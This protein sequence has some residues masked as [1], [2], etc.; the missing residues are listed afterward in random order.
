M[1]KTYTPS[2]I[3]KKW[4][5]IWEQRG[6]FKPSGEG[7]AYCI[8]IPP[9]N[10]TGF[11]HMGHGF[12][13]TLMD[14]LIRYHRMDG[15][16][17][18]WQTGTDHAGIATQMVVERQLATQKL[19]RHDLGREAFVE[20]VWEWKAESG[21]HITRQMRRI[22]NSADW[23]REAF[24]MDD[25]LSAAVKKVFVQLYD[26]G[27]IYR[28]KR[29]VN[30]DPVL[31][32]AISDVEVINET[33][34]G[35][36]WYL[37]YPL[38][39]GS[40]HLIVATTRPETMLGD[41]AVAVNPNDERYQHLIGKEIALPLTSRKIP[42]IGDDYA[43]PKFGTGCVKITPAH[44]FNDYEVGLRHQLRLI[45]ILTPDAKINHEAPEKYRGLDRFVA[46]EKIIED[47]KA[48][49]LLEKIE[50]HTLNVPIGDRGGAVIEPYLTNQ[51]YVD[52][53]P[54]AK[55]AIDAV[56][57]GRIR[58]VPDTWNKTYFQWMDNIQDWCISRQL[59]WGHRIPA[60]YDASGN[61]YVADDEMTVRE[62]Y[63]L[64]KS[65][66]LTQDND[67]LDTWFSSALWPFSTLGWPEKT[68]ALKIFY[69]T[70]VL[71][72]G[73]D[74][75]F[76]WVARMIMFG[77][78]FAGDVPFHDIYITGLIR[79]E[80]GQKMSKTK[81]NVLDPIDLV[82][83]ISLED[84][85]AKRTYGLMQTHLI[86]T[87]IDNTRKQFPEGIAAHGMDA[88]RF[89]FCALASTGR[90]IRFDLGRLEGYKNFCNKIWNATRFVLM[91][92][93]GNS[94]PCVLAGE[95]EGG[96]KNLAD[97]WILSRLQNAIHEFRSHLNNYRFDLASQA[98]YDFIWNEYCDWYL[99][100]T[101]PILYNDTTS[102]TEKAGTRHTLIF[103][104]ETAL[105][106]LH[107]FMPFMT[108]E[109]WQTVKPLL[110]IS[111]DSIMLQPYPQVDNS[112]VNVSA[113]ESVELFKAIILGVRTIRGEMGIPPS[114]TVKLYFDKASS[115]QKQAI[116][117][118]QSFLL[119]LA[120]CESI[121][122]G[123]PS[124]ASAAAL[125]SNLELFIPLA[126]FIDKEAEIQRLNKEIEKFK[127]E[128]VIS[129][130][131]LDN[132]GYVAKAPA[133]V[134][135]KERDKLIEKETNL[136]KLKMQL[137]KIKNI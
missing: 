100:F 108:E 8:M 27:L 41:S 31:L 28:G 125:A 129:S 113:E 86:D 137:E 37:R 21:G 30:W 70:S 96:G 92:V 58:F 107:P 130:K 123:N 36:M 2:D 83:G 99:E 95:G 84:L 75:I 25:N 18:L 63:N 15:D 114:K 77:L 71:M 61:V 111:G 47:L 101:K 66:V 1:E 6:Y 42:I 43:D 93:E 48:L 132:Q 67:V 88:L 46:R 94:L 91:N 97:A 44:D 19:A 119:A 16:N 53:K 105:R 128:I 89:T 110:A 103:V 32:T 4:Y 80:H 112:L 76:F 45:N 56:K 136:E 40:G 17:T 78:K 14:V 85:L 54:L 11:L 59:W 124:A 98:I 55:P 65:I 115:T 62:K 102:D 87:I 12:Q 116:E 90:D 39:D 131:K 127:A 38:A 49:G 50:P 81:G 57:D 13:Q 126:G 51:W 24:T 118:N 69:P 7:K 74:I 122:E 117:H 120:K 34:E 73:F 29:L 35:F 109:I 5:D 52:I 26:E 60:W 20:K 72:T 82:D 135:A 133:E 106:L 10:V 33:R 22:G 79:D 23:S 134:V 68:E 3:E 121:T 104:L 64:N 9:P